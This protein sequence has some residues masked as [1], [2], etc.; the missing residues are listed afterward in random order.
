MKQNGNNKYIYAV[1]ST[2]DTI[3]GVTPVSKPLSYYGNSSHMPLHISTQK[4]QYS[5]SQQTLKCPF[6]FDLKCQSHSYT[7]THLCCHY[8]PAHTFMS[9][10]VSFWFIMYIVE[11]LVPVSLQLKHNRGLVYVALIST[12]KK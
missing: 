3:T 6:N 5:C 12:S 11:M 8:S 7:D 2:S 9:L 4:P 10:H 1:R